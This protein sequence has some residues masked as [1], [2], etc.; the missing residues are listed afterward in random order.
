MRTACAVALCLFV[1]ALAGCPSQPPV[2]PP[3]PD[4][5]DASAP[6]VD[7]Q[8][9]VGDAPLTPCESACANLA[10]LE[11]PPPAADCATVMAHVESMRLIRTTAGAPL[12]CAALAAATSQAAVSALGV[13]CP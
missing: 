10:A 6:P 8:H 12:T 13:K 4:A 5:S 2:V 1:S 3:G 9:V 11:C 7:A